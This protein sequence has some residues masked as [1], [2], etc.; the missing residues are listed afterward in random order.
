M[1]RERLRDGIAQ[2]EDIAQDRGDPE[3]L[4][5]VGAP[6][7][8]QRD[9]QPGVVDPVGEPPEEFDHAHH[10]PPRPGAAQQQSLVQI[11]REIVVAHQAH[12]IV[13]GQGRQRTA[14]E[15]AGRAPGGQE[16]GRPVR[17]PGDRH[18]LVVGGQQ[19]RHV[20]GERGAAARRIGA[21]VAAAGDEPGLVGR[22][23]AV[24]PGEPFRART[25]LAHRIECH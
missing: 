14:P 18:Q 8:G 21:A 13:I 20:P 1:R 22:P 23:G 5:G 15:I 24:P 3:P 11:G 25:V 9:A 4:G 2:L 12:A 17:A 16:P 19:F 7:I 10:R 6:A